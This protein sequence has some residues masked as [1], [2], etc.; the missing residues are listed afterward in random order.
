MRLLCVFSLFLGS[1]Y[2]QT[3]G[4]IEGVVTDPSGSSVSGAQVRVTETHTGAVRRF[5]TGADGSYVAPGLAPGA[6]EILVESRNFRATTRR[7]VDL[8]AGRSL[9]IDFQLQIGEQS[10][11]IIVE[12][13]TPLVSPNAG[14]WG[15][16]VSQ[17]RLEEL[18]LNGRD[19]FELAQRESGA[20]LSYT[21]QRTQ[22]YGRA[23][24]MSVNGARPS[25]NGYRI[26]GLYANDAS[27]SAPA[28]A[29]GQTLGIE[30]VQ[31]L[32][33]VSSPFMAEYGRAAG[34]VFTAV[35][36]SGSNDF[37]GS[38]FEFLRNS[39]M[40]AKN[41]FDPAGSPTPPLKK[42]QF[43]GLISGP[44][45]QNRLF[46]LA[47]YEGV[48]SVSGRTSIAT[49]LGPEAR[50]GNLPGGHV[51]VAPG[52][53]PFLGIY[54]QPN[55]IR[56]ADGTG[57]YITEL[58]TRAHED[59]VTGKLDYLYSERLRFNTRYTFDRGL[60][61]TPDPF[62]IWDLPYISGHHFA[63]IGI[64]FTQSPSTLHNLRAGFSRVDN[65]YT[66][67]QSSRIPADLSFAP[68][69]PLGAM[70]VTGLTE[71]GGQTLRSLPFRYL[72]N[73]YQVNW[74][75][76]QV[77]GRHTIKAGAG[78]DRVQFNQNFAQDAFGSYIFTSVANL[79]TGKP[80][81]GALLAP[82]Q[83]TVR[84]WRQSLFYV[85]VQDEFRISR[86]VQ[87]SAGLRY[88]PYTT[89]AE[90]NGLVSALPDPLHD[91][92][93]TVGIG[94]FRNP[95]KANFAPRLAVAWD[96]SGNGRT[97]FRAGAGIFYD[98][99]GVRDVTFGGARLP[100]F[101]NR[102]QA[103]NPSFPN[104]AAAVTASAGTVFDGMQY[105]AN[106]PYASQMQAAI[107]HQWGQ[108]T[109][110]R[111]GY[112]GNRGIHLP[113]FV[114]NANIPQPSTLPNGQLYFSPSAPVLNPHFARIGL[115]LTQ[116][117]SSSNALQLHA[118]H[119]FTAGFR[120]QLNY[121]Y[122]KVI[123]QSSNPNFH[124]FLNDDYMPFPLNFRANRGPASFDL[125]QVFAADWSWQTRRFLGGWEFHGIFQA[126]SGPPFNPI[127]GFDRAGLRANL[128]PDVGQRP[129]YVPGVPVILGDPAQWYNPA[130]FEL[131]AAGTYG[132]LGRN[133]L[134]GP[135][136]VNADLAVHKRLWA[137]ERSQVNLRLEVFNI[138]NH[139]NFQIPSSL[140]LFSSN[141]RRV[142]SAGQITQ[143]TTTSRQ[144]QI[145]LRANF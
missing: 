78:F 32:R 58:D 36:K 96:L 108:R 64:Q 44:I 71:V 54:P 142:A 33:L 62:L 143:T 9:R 84:G 40:D 23:Q 12:A 124:E 116:F 29:S 60:S 48:R 102:P 57:Q 17:Q 81:S 131:P 6:Y 107:E 51:P 21:S 63:A 90:V 77:K 111:V 113:G 88:E 47:N 122:G 144:L 112:A 10:Q 61:T 138:A 65:Q 100:P 129:I 130:A 94:L 105:Y 13:A 82:G 141:G 76:T 86:R 119:R 121:A 93:V 92:D 106:Q 135:G 42:N 98:T 20:A 34:G 35:S 4:E 46:F 27:G 2:A 7:G 85:F 53:V 22:Y 89:P 125:R 95:S 117:P 123:D 127:I 55:G 19:I 67:S 8:D 49:T 31:E 140:S 30:A 136:L 45:V 139:P 25:Q 101:Y 115:R 26:D 11:T 24:H 72:T 99:I 87:V 80:S 103:V 83:S 66:S 134:S 109:V 137:N 75:V 73:D 3:T 97:V 18:P 70:L 114:G 41:F 69:L 16:S 39:A 128:A 14:D 28:S 74:D 59:Y 145:G 118:S 43:G 38:V 133:T 50:L 132:N 52:V 1:A 56:F 5:A 110:F 68:G 126:Q 104:L 91:T 15:S 79:L 120:F 37:H